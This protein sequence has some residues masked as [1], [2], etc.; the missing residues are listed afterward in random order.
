MS[1]Q[2]YAL[3]RERLCSV[4]P[5]NSLVVLSAAQ[6]VY[7][8]GIIPYPYRQVRAWPANLGSLGAAGIQADT[9]AG[10]EGLSAPVHSADTQ[11]VSPLQSLTTCL[12]SPW[13]P[14]MPSAQDADFYYLTG[15]NQ[16]GVLVLQ[17]RRSSQGHSRCH[18]MLFLEPRDAEVSTD[19]CAC[20]C[21]NGG[22]SLIHLSLTYAHTPLF[23]VAAR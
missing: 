14:H 17:A 22:R 9:A 8:S 3:R 23:G 19:W 12:M 15:L 11:L 20:A 2:E 21:F 1:W 18:Y 6:T 5:E 16:Q 7:M 4:L 10:V 13:P